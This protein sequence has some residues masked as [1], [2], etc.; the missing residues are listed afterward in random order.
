[1]KL[2]NFIA[3]LNK[4]ARE[5]GD[6]LEVIM[7]DDVPVVSPVLSAGYPGGERVVVTDKKR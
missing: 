5:R 7:A 2:K 6:D 4:I 1:M 3:Q